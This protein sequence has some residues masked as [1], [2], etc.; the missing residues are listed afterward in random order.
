[1][2]KNRIKD[3]DTKYTNWHC[4]RIYI[5]MCV[6]VLCM[7]VYMYVCMCVLHVCMYVYMC[8]CVWGGMCV[9]GLYVYVMMMID[10]LRP[11]L[12]TR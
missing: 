7:Y 10:V 1:M 3:L 12:C 8:I 5:Y 4:L 9:E 11:P 2:S 6:C